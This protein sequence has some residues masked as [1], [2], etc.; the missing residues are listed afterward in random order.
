MEQ[1]PWSIFDAIIPDFDRP[2][3]ISQ[4]ISDI[5]NRVYSKVTKVLVLWWSQIDCNC[6][7]I[8]P[9][10]SQEA[11]VPVEGEWYVNPFLLY[12]VP[13]KSF[14][15]SWFFLTKND[16][17]KCAQFIQNLY[18]LGI[19]KSCQKAFWANIPLS[20]LSSWLT[21][22]LKPRPVV[23]MKWGLCFPTSTNQ[24][25]YSGPGPALTIFN[26]L[27]L[28]SFVPIYVPRNSYSNNYPQTL[29][30]KDK[31]RTHSY[32]LYNLPKIFTNPY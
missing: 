15:Q 6:L 27:S 14:L 10:E 3:D 2:I 1:R 4:D 17:L 23:P 22:K 20:E 31:K 5:R 30:V 29:S 28:L 32:L 12:R 21:Y 13:Y 24:G 18:A 25:K 9:D 16:Y 8:F 7:P 19:K 11:Y 26:K